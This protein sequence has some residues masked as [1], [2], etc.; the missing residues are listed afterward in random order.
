MVR[1]DVITFKVDVPKLLARMALLKDQIL[2][3]KFVGPRPHPQDMRR[4]LQALN[5]EFRGCMLTS[6]RNVGKG[7]F[8]LSGDDRDALNN[9]LMLSSFKT[10]WGTCMFQSWVLGF[11]PDNPSNLAFPTWVTL[12][13]LPYEHHDQAIGIAEIFGEVIGISTTNETTK[14]PRFCINLMVNKGWATSIDL[15]SGGEISPP[16]RVLVDY[17]NLPIRCKACHNW[18]HRVR[19]CEETRKKP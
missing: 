9:A 15:D 18:K 11:N 13:K 14:D 12:R 17:D 1:K 6:C 2:I 8:F 3:A 4:W 10:K 7:F 5:H 19:D 16:Q